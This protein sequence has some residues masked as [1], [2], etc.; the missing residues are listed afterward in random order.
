MRGVSYFN[1]GK[2]C[3]VRLCISLFSLRKVYDGPVAIL[4]GG[5]DDGICRK[6]GDALEANIVD[7]PIVQRRRHTAYCAKASMW[8]YTPF[9]TNL[10]LDA[11]TAVLSDPTIL[12][13]LAE[14]PPY[15]CVTRFANWVTT[16]KLI[17]GRI[18]RWKGVKYPGLDKMI[19]E[20]LEAPHGAVNTGVLSWSA[21]AKPFLE[22]WEALTH[23]G[24]R[25]PFTD[26]LAAQALLRKH[27]HLMLD[28]RYNHSFRYPISAEPII[29][30]YHGN[31]A[32]RPGGALESW[33]PLYQECLK[34][35]VAD[36]NQWTPADDP[37]LTEYLSENNR[38]C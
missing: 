37:A 32:C 3:L 9:D 21:G 4:S 5:G 24:W 12:L 36:I 35:N 13:E 7:M 20:N 31:K 38:P 26:E 18:E 30:H 28:S 15:L 10:F 2:K 25:C 17:R 29:A 19:H 11:D 8:R 14:Q 34:Q 16:G 22:E 27:E 6:I 33:W 23:A 1:L